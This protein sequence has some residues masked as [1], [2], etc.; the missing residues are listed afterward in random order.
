M[1]HLDK[2]ELAGGGGEPRDD[3]RYRHKRTIPTAPRLCPLLDNRGQRR[4]LAQNGLSAFDPKADI[5]A[6]AESDTSNMNKASEKSLELRVCPSVFQHR[7]ITA[8]LGGNTCAH[9]LSP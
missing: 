5:T 9:F 6:V 7:L 2:V 1:W 4:I 3:V 8:D